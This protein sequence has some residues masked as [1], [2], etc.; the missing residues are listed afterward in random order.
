ML[1]RRPLAILFSGLALLVAAP[2]AAQAQTPS[3]PAAAKP[4]DPFGEKLTLESHPMIVRKGTAN[5][6]SA[7]ETLV[8]A[9]KSVKAYMDKEG[10]QA[11]G[12]AMT[13]YLSTDDTGFQFEAGYP[14]AEA[15][16]NP[17]TG[18]LAMSK[19]PDGN[20]LKF[21]HRGSFDAMDSTYEAITN[22]LDEKQLDA[23][24]V[25][26]EEYVTDPTTATD[27]KLVINVLV[28]VK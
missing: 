27:D 19:S 6:D 1:P 9:F 17:P 22:Y 10:I 2:I 16:K 12:L 24:D 5:W 15:P 23:R 3:P 26:V 14:V 25:F 11:T 8:D 21:V 4:A 28:P 20:A 7:F 18:D 13:M